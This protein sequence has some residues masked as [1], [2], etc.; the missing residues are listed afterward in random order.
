MVPTRKI[1]PPI[2]MRMPIAVGESWAG[3][4]VESPEMASVVDAENDSA[5]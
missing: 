5:L 4:E 1:V 2:T 3:G